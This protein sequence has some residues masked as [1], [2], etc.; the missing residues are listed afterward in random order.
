MF[1]RKYDLECIKT[2]GYN[3]LNKEPLAW[4]VGWRRPVL[5]FGCTPS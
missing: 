3:E 4:K 1:Y 5:G 2:N